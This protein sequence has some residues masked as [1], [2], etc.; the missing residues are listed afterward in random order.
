MSQAPT[1]SKQSRRSK[2]QTLQLEAYDDV[3]SIRDRLQYVEQ[4]RVLLIFPSNVK[5]LRRKL[6]LLLIQREAARRNLQLALLCTDPDVAANAASLNLSCFFSLRQARSHPWKNARSKIF[7]DRSS[8]PATSLRSPYELMHR[9]SRLKPDLTTRQRRMQFLARIGIGLVVVVVMLGTIG[10]VIPSATV[11][12][13]PAYDAIQEPITIT[14]DSTASEID[15]RN[16]IIPAQ[17]IRIL[18]QGDSVTIESSGRREGADSLARGRVIL[19]NETNNPLF[20]PAGT[21]VSTATA[22]PA[23][24]QITADVPLAAQVGSTG[25]SEIVALADTGGLIGNVPANAITRVEGEL[26][27]LVSVRNPN[28]TFGGGLVEEAIV[29]ADDHERL[30]TLARLALQQAGRNQL[31]LQLPTEDKFLVP[32]SVKVVE[33]RPEW[34]T[35]SAQIGDAAPSVSLDMRGVV[36]AVVV[37]QLQARQL[38]FIMLS[39]RLPPGREL[40]QDALTYRREDIG[41]DA[42]GRFTFRMFVEGELPFRIDGDAVANRIN[43]M[44]V[45]AAKRTLENELLLDPNHPPEISIFPLN[46][47]IMPFLPVRIRVEVDRR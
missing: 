2:I 31:L 21:I 27:T 1:R 35:F 45:G 19:T 17:V 7:L 3:T 15:P 12:L 39:Q 40:D 37:D 22:P 36:E 41:L 16:A 14:A 33:E 25:E 42:Q 44:T 30:R 11:R 4:P 43:G 29:T 26:E 10:A 23:R 28:P 34:F 46:F 24:F 20:I 38:A 6:D 32:D 18:V 47:G 9:V 5:I 8:R 13:T